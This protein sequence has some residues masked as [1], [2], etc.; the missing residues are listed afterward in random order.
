G[1]MAPSDIDL[2]NYNAGCDC[3]DICYDDCC[4]DCYGDSCGCCPGD[5]CNSY[6][7]GG[8]LNRMRDRCQDCNGQGCG[9]CRGRLAGMAARLNP[10][11]Q[12]YPEMTTFNPSPPVGQVAYPY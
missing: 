11:A 5:G 9:R 12:G 8:L 4:G 2:V 1:Q 7:Q 10:H 3:G 6:G